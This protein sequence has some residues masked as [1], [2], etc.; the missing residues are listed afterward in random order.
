M[1]K[2]DLQELYKSCRDFKDYVHKYC[3]KHK[4]MLSEDDE[5][6]DLDTALEHEII[7]GIGLMY[8]VK[9]QKHSEG[10]LI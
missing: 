8:A 7:K 3:R 5:D 9:R 4:L 10:G 2:E 6:C 1:T